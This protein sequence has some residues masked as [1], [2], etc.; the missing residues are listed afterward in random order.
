MDFIDVELCHLEED[1]ASASL[2]EGR[3]EAM[4]LDEALEIFAIGD[5]SEVDSAEVFQHRFDVFHDPVDQVSVLVE[6]QQEV[7]FSILVEFSCIKIDVLL[8]I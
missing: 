1:I 3:L 6:G 8:A 2:H 5:F 4:F 7:D